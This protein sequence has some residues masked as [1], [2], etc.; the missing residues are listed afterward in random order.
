MVTVA[1]HGERVDK[2][3]DRNRSTRES[4]LQLLIRD[5]FPSSEFACCIPRS[6]M[7]ALEGGGKDVYCVIKALEKT[8]N[9]RVRHCFADPINRSS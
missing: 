1:L 3:T 4:Q 9:R 7:D 5:F 8:A 6:R 2:H